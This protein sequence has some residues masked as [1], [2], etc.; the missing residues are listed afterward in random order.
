MKQE[1]TYSSPAKVILSGEHAVVYG[2]PALISA[3]DFRLWFTVWQSQKTAKDPVVLYIS[4]TV[5]KY[6][7]FK[8]ISFKDKH[9]DFKISSAIPRRCGLGSSAALSV[10]AVASFLTFYT[11]REFDCEMV[12]NISYKIEKYFHQNPSGA[13]NTTCCFGGL[14]FF[15][16]EFEFLKTISVLNF[17]I[18][19][20]I[21]SNLYLINSGRP[22]EKT[23]EMVNFVGKIYNQN[24]K[25][26]DEILCDIEKNTKRMTIALVKEDNSFFKK[27]IYENQKLLE[28]LGVVSLH[29]KKL[30][31]DLKNFGVGKIT[32]AGG[33][34][35]GS[36][37][38]LFY[39]DRPG[40]IESYF[41]ERSIDFVKF[42]QSRLG[43]K[44]G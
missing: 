20:K 15:R 29:A 2:K 9:F 31:N 16:R 36:G 8:K 33:Q 26:I 4:N 30:L 22:K 28:K 11:G 7:L 12:N 41:R 3:V 6:L 32:G 24:P 14:V 21:E 27:T 39:A 13:D 37:Y 5:K 17:K 35:T 42:K 40:D 43:L 10:S 44:K 18:P 19:E 23:K 25:Q 1:I 38:L 34:K